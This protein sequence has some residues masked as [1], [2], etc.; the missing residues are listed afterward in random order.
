MTPEQKEDIRGQIEAIE[1]DINS[2][3]YAIRDAEAEL[4]QL[5]ELLKDL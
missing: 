2:A 5:R 3:K 4:E 1:V